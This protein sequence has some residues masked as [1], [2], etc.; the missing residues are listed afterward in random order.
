IGCFGQKVLLSKNFSLS[1]RMVTNNEVTIFGH[2]YKTDKRTNITKNIISKLGRNLHLSLYHPLS[3]IRQRIINHF[4]MHFLNRIGN[5]TFSVYDNISPIVTVAKNFDSLLVP[6]DHVSRKDS[7]CYYINQNTL[8]RGHTTAHQTE[9]ISM[10]L[11]NFLVI[12]DVYRRDEINSTHYPVFHQVDGVRLCTVKEVFQNVNILDELRLF[13]HKG[14]ETDEKQACHTL[15]SVKIMEHEL[16]STLISLAQTLFGSEVQCKWVEVYFPFT[17]PSWELEIYHKEQWLEILGCGIIR[18][19]ILLNSGAGERIG[20]AF[21]LGLERL[22]MCV[23]D[24]PDIRLFWSKDIGF[25]N[26]FKVEDP[27]AVIKYKEISIYPSCKNDVSFWLP[28]NEYYS[29]NDFYDI[30]REIGGD[31]IEQV[32][33]KDEFT[34]PITKKLSHC[35]TIVYRH[36]NR[37]MMKR[38]VNNIHNQIKKLAVEKLHVTMR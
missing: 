21:G 30:V 6:E 12:G 2:K 24:I 5:P 20:W 22:A 23:Y 29:Q 7:N 28:E 18:Q 33:L 3:H 27:N 17:H 34:H 4:Y 16:K 31:Y 26:Q 8:L 38:E 36:M 35:Y 1:T 14:I 19:K 32:I 37:T 9:L 25:L 15:E 11:N 10:G 13:E